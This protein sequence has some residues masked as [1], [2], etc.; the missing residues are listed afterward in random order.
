[1]SDLPP[2]FF[3][4]IDP[5][6]RRLLMGPGPSNVH[7]RVLRAMSAAVLGQF[8]PEFTTTMN[9]VMALYRAVFETK[10]RWTMMIDGTSRAAIEAAMVSVL[11]PGDT[12]LVV[13]SGRFGLLLQ[14]IGQRCQ[15]K[16]EIVE[17]P[18]GEIVAMERVAEAAKRIRPRL[19][20]CVHGDTSTTMAQP[21][22]GLG[23]I[24]RDSGALSYVDA[25][26]TLGGMPVPVDAW[27]ADI[28]S[29]GLQKC[30]GG[31][32]GIAP[33]TISDR[34]AERIYA[35]R[36]VE[37]GIAGATDKASNSPP[38]ASNYFD[39]AMVM[40]YW[41]EKRFNHHTEAASMIYAA[42][43]C[44]RIVLGEGL[45][46]RF[47]RHQTAG[48]AMVAGIEAMGL[49]VYGDRANKMFNACGVFIPQG[50]NG[51]SLRKRMREEFEIEIGTSFGPLAGKIW[52]IGTMAGNARRHHVVHTLMAMEA[53]LRREG[54]TAPAGAAADAALA[55]YDKAGG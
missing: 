50:V 38:I 52:R 8:D 22:E 40:D 16:V 37:K 27:G 1:M 7:P 33:I 2:D 10:N 51:D 4:E 48:A 24:A 35:R 46:K 54:F 39:L 6:D 42:R 41:S 19:I 20:A 47:R 43:E 21:L 44:A 26:A 29:A 11:E 55:V 15:A 5:P 32:P 14:E 12:V 36:H 25:T 3:G 13:S 23:V 45:E 28:V 9:E 30:L 34:A 17:A 53:A 49:K 18:W 31:P